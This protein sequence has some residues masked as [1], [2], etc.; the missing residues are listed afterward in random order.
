M[1]KLKEHQSG[2]TQTLILAALTVVVVTCGCKKSERE[3][4]EENAIKRHQQDATHRG[5]MMS[6]AQWS[7]YV[8]TPEG[9]QMLRAI[10]G[11]DFFK[12][13]RTNGQVPGI[14]KDTK[15]R[16]I[17][18]KR[19]SEIPPDGGCSVEVHFLTLD[20]PRQNY[21]YIVT[22]A[23]SNSPWHFQ[24]AWHADWSGKVIEE[25]PVQ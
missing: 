6:P 25:Y 20:R 11:L 19:P 4:A 14:S 23:T 15:G 17:V 5:P 24:K 21:Y 13:S 3:I 12:S 2:I 10:N 1:K 8:R 9:K 22:Q 16:G 7:N 18:Q